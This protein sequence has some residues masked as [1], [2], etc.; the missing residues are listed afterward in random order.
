MG[1][2]TFLFDL[3]GTL[4]DHFQAIHRSYVYTMNCLGL[5]KPTLEQVRSAV[6]GGLER[7]FSKLIATQYHK[8]GLAIYREYWDKTMLDDVVLLPGAH[9]LLDKLHKR[10]ATLG[11]CTNKH[12]PSAR[13][14][15]DHLAISRYMNAI[16]GAGD[17]PWLKPAK[18][19]TTH[20]LNLLGCSTNLAVFVGDSPYDIQAAHNGGIASW[21]VTTGTHTDVELKTAGADAI[22]AN[23]DLMALDL[24]L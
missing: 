13:R 5:P 22:Y 14:I 3:D 15:C 1:F 9:N 7:A 20:T 21:C 12:G 10:G 17:T 11:V 16:V 6:G 19:M 18:E 8:E 4:V 2:R 24:G 23:F